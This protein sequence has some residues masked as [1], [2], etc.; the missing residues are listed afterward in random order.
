M[1]KKIEEDFEPIFE[2]EEEMDAFFARCAEK[3][4]SIHDDEDFVPIIDSSVIIDE[5]GNVELI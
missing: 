1:M 3:R 4:A 2:S 5:D